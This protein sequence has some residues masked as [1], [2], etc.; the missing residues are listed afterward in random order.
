MR[1]AWLGVLG[2][3]LVSCTT[4]HIPELS[5]AIPEE[6]K[7]TKTQVREAIVIAMIEEGWQSTESTPGVFEATRSSLTQEASIYIAYGYEG[8]SIEYADSTN[9][10]YNADSDTISGVYKKWVYALYSSIQYQL[11]EQAGEVK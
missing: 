11:H 8:F 5:A 4:P 2:F 3:F 1:N 7:M 6:H 10:E 9:M